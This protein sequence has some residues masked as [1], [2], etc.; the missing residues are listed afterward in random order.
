MNLQQ[1]HSD[2]TTIHPQTH[3]TPIHPKAQKVTRS[4]KR[5]RKIHKN[6][7]TKKDETTRRKAITRQTNRKAEVENAKP[8][9]EYQQTS[10][11][12]KN[13]HQ[14][15][16]YFSTSKATA[17]KAKTTTP[18]CKRNLAVSNEDYT[19]NSD[20]ITRNNLRY[21][22]VSFS[23]VLQ[24]IQT[25]SQ[26]ERNELPV[27]HQTTATPT[28]TNDTETHPQHST[29]NSQTNETQYPLPNIPWGDLMSPCHNT[30]RIV[31]QNINGMQDKAKTIG[32]RSVEMNI[33][34]LG[35]I[36]TNTDWKH[37]A[38][39]S[40]ETELLKTKNAIKAFYNRVAFSFSHSAIRFKHR[41]QPGGTL[42]I[43]NSKWATRS[44]TSTDPTGMGRW[45]SITMSGKKDRKVTIISAYRVCDQRFATAGPKTA[46]RQQY[47]MA[48]ILGISPNDPRSRIL[49]DLESEIKKIHTDDHAIIILIDANESATTHQSKI[50]SWIS[51]N[52]LCDI[53]TT[54]HGLADQPPTMADGSAKIDYILTSRH[55]TP[56]ISA[57][58]ILPHD[59]FV[60][61]DHRAQ[62]M[63]VDIERY[64]QGIPYDNISHSNRGIRSDNPKAVAKYQELILKA[65][66]KC[67]LEKSLERLTINQ[68]TQGYLTIL[69]QKQA[70]LIDIKITNIKLAAE[71]KCSRI[72]KQP[73]S[74]ILSSLKAATFYWRSWIRQLKTNTDRSEYRRRIRPDIQPL[75]NPTSTQIHRL[76]RSASK[77]YKAA[78]KDG[79]T[80][81]QEHM[82]DLAT[83]RANSGNTALE[84]IILQIIR[85]EQSQATY[86]ACHR[87]LHKPIP[88]PTT[89]IIVTSPG[90][91]QKQIADRSPMEKA[92]TE[93]NLKHFSQADSTPFASYP[94]KQTFGPNGTNDTTRELLAGNLEASHPHLTEATRAILDHLPL[95]NTPPIDHTMHI[96]E[97]MRSYSK[98]REST[99]T[100]P[101][102]DHL[103]H[104]KAI[105]RK[106]SKPDGNTDNSPDIA[107]RMFTIKTSLINLAIENCI[108]Y[109]RWTTVINAMIEKIPGHPLLEKFR[110][111][112]IIPA[113]FNMT[114]G[115]LFGYR[116]MRSGEKLKQFGEE[117]SGSRKNKDCQDVQSFKHSVFSIVRLSRAHGSSFDNDAKSCF[118]RIVMLF[119]SILAQRLG[120]SEKACNLFLTTLSKIEYKTKT[121]HGI[122]EAIYTT[123]AAH[124]IHG[125]GQGSRAAPAIWTIISCYLLSLMKMKS[126]GV[127]ITDPENTITVQ[128]SSTG[129]VDDI[130]HYNINILESL[131]KPEQPQTLQETTLILAQWWENLLHSSGGKLELSKCF[132]Y[133][134]HWMFDLQGAATF[135]P[136]STFPDPIILIDSVTKEPTVI[137]HKPCSE[138]H[139]TLGKMENPTGNY[140]DESKRITEKADG[141]AYKIAASGLSYLE[142][143]TLHNTMYLPAVSYG[144]Q[145]G[146]LSLKQAEKA[147]SKMILAILPRLGFHRNTP[148]EVVFANHNSG[149]V[150]LRH[151]FAEQGSRQI[152]SLMQNVRRNTPLGKALLIQLKWAQ[153]IAGTS[154]PIL[155]DPDR[156][157]PQLSAERWIQTLRIFLKLSKLKIDI[158]Q[159]VTSPPKRV[160]DRYIMDI[161][162]TDG[163][164]SDSQITIINRCRIHLRAETI[165]DLSNASGTTLTND[166]I[167]CTY[168]IGGTQSLWPQQTKPH[169]FVPWTKFLNSI[170]NKTNHKLHTPLGAW[171]T[172]PNANRQWPSH[173]DPS[174]RTITFRKGLTWYISGK[175]TQSRH[176]WET[177]ATTTRENQH[178]RAN[179]N[180][181]PVDSIRNHK[182]SS[183]S[184]KKPPR[185]VDNRQPN[186]QSSTWHEYTK[187]LTPWSRRIIEQTT[188]PN[189]QI[190]INAL[191][192]Y[193]TEPI[194]IASDGSF[195][196]EKGAIAWTMEL[197][198][199]TIAHGTGHAPGNPITSLRTQCYG[200]LSWVVFL[201]HFLLFH[202]IH[203]TSRITTFCDSPQAISHTDSS[204]VD[205]CCYKPCT[206]DFD[207]IT[208]LNSEYNKLKTSCNLLEPIS[209]IKV[210]RLTAMRDYAQL[211]IAAVS[212][213]SADKRYTQRTPLSPKF[214]QSEITL[215]TNTGLAITSNERIVCRDRWRN[216]LLHKWYADKFKVSPPIILRVNWSAYQQTI[217]SLKPAMRRFGIKLLTGWLPV[218][219]RLQY[220]GNEI[221]KC[222][223]CPMAETPSHLFTCHTRIP[224]FI[225]RNEAFRNLLQKL[226]T[227]PDI[228]EAIADGI[229]LWSTDAPEPTITEALLK[230]SDRG[231]ICYKKQEQ[232]GWRQAVSGIMDKC[233]SEHIPDTKQ[234]GKGNKWQSAVSKW[235]ILDAWEIWMERNSER[236][237]TDK[238]AEITAREAETQARVR[239][240]YSTAQA[241]LDLNE[242]NEFIHIPLNARLQYPEKTNRI[243]AEQLIQVIS[244]RIHLN[245]TRTTTNN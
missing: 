10:Q 58:G 135:S 70:N 14:R 243:W 73:W 142:T 139:K 62:F 101:A 89:H 167:T 177:S 118:D 78:L 71:K 98:W 121:I 239:L 5:Q 49:I 93:R 16:T 195:C 201:K 117:Q 136:K 94:L 85:A 161:A 47:I 39:D 152:R 1:L 37:K 169:E 87:A 130:T 80:L 32:E 186:K 150:G 242:Y 181:I 222:H 15:P 106:L 57:S 23:P 158:K 210:H 75:R 123:T 79:I 193:S 190:L 238:P 38:K 83:M 140:D 50:A 52:N 19:N 227:P 175:L 156:N 31:L 199:E 51:R 111:I 231:I 68:R 116:M 216:N 212:K 103:G 213:V 241:K 237:A 197:K 207:I 218:G 132:Y 225:K 65:L 229:F 200:I 81:R 18:K 203:A 141:Y 8:L 25:D 194:Y 91:T 54:S 66:N 176:K 151:L 72:T 40:S 178:F 96:E 209:H 21:R 168:R 157:I 137:E 170:S 205:T 46:Y 206:P 3:N 45:S 53:L 17:P 171:T 29:P 20:L 145:S 138:S 187:Q 27:T 204:P 134:F 13:R 129:F 182:E 223:R 173:Y 30:C 48:D 219:T 164:Y 146:T 202:E 113:D 35:L 143:I 148:R 165:A 64:L 24:I 198:N 110:V 99:S 214:E 127:I 166:A 233:W 160:H 26:R 55:L 196:Y 124:T 162:T 95:P 22:C 33:S 217:S 235:L 126:Q 208:V 86:S 60:E 224:H 159:I 184:F 128:Q 226:K 120:M 6:K 77:E 114:M 92:L 234:S 119:P 244:T 97:M 240:V 153:K 67:S 44:N 42:T 125:P 183:S 74:P 11:R 59:H 122:S 41:Y 56:Y 82:K 155:S 7:I 34:V 220:Y 100:S 230:F 112:H 188:I 108:V 90:G 163:D 12:N 191:I 107:T 36:E 179:N 9:Q 43:T 185:S 211:L 88:K 174:D 180:H 215:T 189:T 115:T 4:S 61:S 245:M 84:K 63:D 172:N 76:L 236:N 192:N 28:Q 102:G 221:N 2:Q 149:G 133:M 232:L 147:Q 228:S 154:T 131:I 105:L 144:L 69:Q 104:E 109:D